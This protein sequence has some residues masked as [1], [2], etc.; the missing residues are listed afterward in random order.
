[1]KK[2]VILLIFSFFFISLAYAHPPQD[3]KITFNKENKT[4]TAVIKHVT[5]NPKTHYIQKVD[6]GLNGKE[7]DDIKLLA[8]DNSTT[9]TITYVFTNIKSQDVISVEAYCNLFGKL[10]KQI[11]VE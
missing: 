10:Q 5:S 9:Q 7:I 11:T 8:Q 2:I 1:M 3:I 6:I 4:L